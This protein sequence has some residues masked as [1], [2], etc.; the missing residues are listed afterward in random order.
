MIVWHLPNGYDLARVLKLWP[1]D[2]TF[3]YLE[4]PYSASERCLK[5]RAIINFVSRELATDFRSKWNGL[6]VHHS[7][8]ARLDICEAH[9]QGLG[10]LLERFL[11]KDITKLHNHGRLPLLCKGV[12]RLN[13]EEVLTMLFN[14]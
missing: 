14:E 10:N 9:V 12:K 13:T 3:N 4:V 2:G 5:G 8:E 11:R 6:W 7:Q 1:L